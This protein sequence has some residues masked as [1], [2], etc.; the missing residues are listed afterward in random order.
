MPAGSPQL[1]KLHFQ[2]YDLPDHG[3]NGVDDDFNLGELITCRQA[4][5]LQLLSFFTNY[6]LGGLRSGPKLYFCA[7]SKLYEFILQTS[8]GLPSQS[9][10]AGR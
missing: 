10:V 8:E 2:N 1:K 3:D 9:I 6:L 7:F 4:F 5:G